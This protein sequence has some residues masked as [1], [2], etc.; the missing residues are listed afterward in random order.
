MWLRR[1]FYHKTNWPQFKTALS[2]YSVET[3]AG[4]GV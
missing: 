3:A 4:Y 1:N 2:A